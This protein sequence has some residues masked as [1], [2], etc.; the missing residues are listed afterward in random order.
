MSKTKEE[1]NRIDSGKQEKQSVQEI[2]ASAEQES[3]EKSYLSPLSESEFTDKLILFVNHIQSGSVKAQLYDLTKGAYSIA[4]SKPEKAE[5]EL[6]TFASTGLQV[7][8]V[9]RQTLNF[10]DFAKM[11]GSALTAIAANKQKVKK[12]ANWKSYAIWASENNSLEPAQSAIKAM[13]ESEEQ[14]KRLEAVVSTLKGND[15]LLLQS[16]ISSAKTIKDTN[17]S[18]AKE[19]WKRY[20]TYSRNC[21]KPQSDFGES[22]IKV[23]ETAQSTRKRD[24]K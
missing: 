1:L 13:K 11:I 15:K 10:D 16:A 14:L 17:E 4:L 5:S 8:Q 6:F 22:A 19:I 18:T 20:C 12:Q 2:A 9:R 21:G 7:W 24:N 3:K 23:M